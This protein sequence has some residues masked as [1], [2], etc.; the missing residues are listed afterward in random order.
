MKRT[1]SALLKEHGLRV[2]DIRKS[3]ISVLDKASGALSNSEIESQL[4]GIDRITL[5]RTLLAFEESGLVH[6]SIDASGQKKYALCAEHCDEH[7]HHDDHVHFHCTKCG[8]TECMDNEV[9]SGFKLPDG[10]HVSEI[11]FNVMG[12]CPKCN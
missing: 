4:E 9:P 1:A 7:E 2:T 5:Y 10:Y 11:Q 12:T 3:C 6:H 8:Q